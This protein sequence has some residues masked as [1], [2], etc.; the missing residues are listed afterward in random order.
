[1]AKSTKQTDTPVPQ[2]NPFY[3]ALNG[4]TSLFSNALSVGIVILLVSAVGSMVST[5]GRTDGEAD[6]RAV[7]NAINQVTSLSIAELSMIAGIGIVIVI[8]GI[9]VGA[10][11][12]GIQSYTAMR[13][14][15][16]EKTTIGEAFN[17]VLGEFGNYLILY[18]WMNFKIFLWTL[19]LIV[20]GIIAY[21]R[22]SFAGVVFFDKKLRSEQAIKESNRLTKGGLMTLFASH[23]L[24]NII[25]LGYIDRVISMAS[26]SELYREY[27]ALDVAKKSKP[28]IHWLSWV[29][30]SLP[31]VLLSMLIFFAVILA[32][33]IGLS[34]AAIT[35]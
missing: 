2:Y 22:Y 32:V 29:T 25:T 19:L 4:I 17:T 20:P 13:L 16:G 18:V 27:T 35:R 31:F 21:Y 12:H 26:V 30:L 33:I 6:Q 5:V 9:V 14:A 34:G 24:F 8:F 23:A 10:M 7:E 28:G 11:L 3:V 15:K 1:M